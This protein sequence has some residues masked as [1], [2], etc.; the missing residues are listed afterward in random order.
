[1]R[2]AFSRSTILARSAMSYLPSRARTGRLTGQRLRVSGPRFACT[3]PVHFQA[4]PEEQA[5][6]KESDREVFRG[7]IQV[8]TDGLPARSLELAFEERV[9]QV[10]GELRQASPEHLPE[11]PTFGLT[12]R[13]AAPVERRSPPVAAT[14]EHD[15]GPVLGRPGVLEAPL[16]AGLPYAV[17]D[18]PLEDGDQPGA[19]RRPAGVGLAARE[20]R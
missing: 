5:G 17:G 3:E 18:L 20:R 8:A 11:F 16:A 14:V 6:P 7:D 13:V 2:R 19:Y 4:S 1:A 10:P 15:F 9:D 12:D